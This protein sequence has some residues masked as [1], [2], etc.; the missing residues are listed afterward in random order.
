MQAPTGGG[1]PFGGGAAAA[2]AA[3]EEGTQEWERTSA[4]APTG[5]GGG[6]G[7]QER[8]QTS[9][10]APTGVPAVPTAP[11][12]SA[13]T[14]PPAAPPKP[15]PAP[16]GEA[17]RATFAFQ[18]RQEDEMSLVVGETIVVTTKDDGGWWTGSKV[19]AAT[20]ARVEGLFPGN[21]VEFI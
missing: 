6:G 9:V 11:S 14:P 12:T 4:A 8:M 19:D 13:F 20:G 18:G 1:N 17:A 16:E 21:Y 10:R 15:G 2:A 5:G 3:D 7:D